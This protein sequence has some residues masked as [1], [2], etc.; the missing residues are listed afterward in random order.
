MAVESASVPD[1]ECQRNP[2]VS[3]FTRHLKGL[4]PVS[5]FRPRKRPRRRRKSRGRNGETKGASTPRAPARQKHRPSRAKPPPTFTS[6]PPTFTSKPASPVL[7]RPTLRVPTHLIPL[8]T[9]PRPSVAR[10][11][12]PGVPLVAGN[13]VPAESP[14]DPSPHGAIGSPGCRRS[15]P[16]VSSPSR[17]PSWRPATR[18]RVRPALPHT[19]PGAAGISLCDSPRTLAW[20]HQATSTSTMPTAPHTN[21][22]T[23]RRGLDGSSAKNSRVDGT[24]K[25]TR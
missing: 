18:S 25:S 5:P 3:S 16:P 10:E 24:V 6:R 8:T 11:L 2:H 19:S 22:A 7:C 1:I 9:R 17:H 14:P 13:T 4:R 21:A 20:T 15:P 12:G 23:V